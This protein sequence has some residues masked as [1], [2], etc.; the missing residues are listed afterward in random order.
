VR[1]YA[2]IALTRV[3]TNFS[4]R[5]ALLE[6]AV[7][8]LR[9]A[10]DGG[11]L[12]DEERASFRRA[13]ALLDPGNAPEDVPGEWASAWADDP[14]LPTIGETLHDVML[15]KTNWFVAEELQIHTISDRPETRRDLASGTERKITAENREL[16]DL[17]EWLRD[18]PYF[19]EAELPDRGYGE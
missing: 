12:G 18:H 13:L 17:R 15:E 2:A 14:V 19:T 1:I 10:L 3:G 8:M 4:E 16:R 6:R 11:S 5:P 7:R 9:S